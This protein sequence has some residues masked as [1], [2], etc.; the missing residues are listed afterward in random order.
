M[1][2]AAS[3]NASSALHVALTTT[4]DYEPACVSAART[5]VAREAASSA[6]VAAYGSFFIWENLLVDRFQAP[7]FRSRKDQ[8]PQAEA[9]ATRIR[10]RSPTR[11]ARAAISRYNGEICF[12][13]ITSL[14]ATAHGSYSRT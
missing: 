8:N 9:H 11:Q 2:F 1:H 3:A 14:C 13:L 4:P 6:R 5:P 12:R 10:F 7:D